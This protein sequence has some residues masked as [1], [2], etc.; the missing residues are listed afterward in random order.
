MFLMVMAPGSKSQDQPL[1]SSLAL[2]H[3]SSQLLGLVLPS[4][5]LLRAAE[6]LQS[7]PMEML[8]DHDP[9]TS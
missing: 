2:F 3:S 7:P 9:A 4:F 1:V 8:V 6:Y 5:A